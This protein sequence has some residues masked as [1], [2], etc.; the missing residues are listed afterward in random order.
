M[1]NNL[2]S[3]SIICVSVVGSLLFM[4]GLNLV[5][6]REERRE[7]NDQIG[8]QLTALGTTYA[9]ILGFMLYAVWTTFGVAE[10]NVDLEANALGQRLPSVG[11]PAGAAT[12]TS[13]RAWHA[14]MRRR[15]FRTTGR[16]WRARKFPAK[17]WKSTPTCG[18]R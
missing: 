11:R 10:V 17:A 15:R 9:V 8:W 3:L 18:E 1:L 2:Q 14:L 12:G 5:W 13:C 16:R 4:W 7:H 6:P